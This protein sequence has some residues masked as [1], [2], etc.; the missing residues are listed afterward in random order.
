MSSYGPPQQYPLTLTNGQQSFSINGAPSGTQQIVISCQSYPSAGTLSLEYK[1]V[2]DSLWRP[3]PKGT[4]LPL[5]GPLVLETYG[6]V[7][8]YRATLAGIVGGAGLVAWIGIGNAEGFPPGS[9]V[10]LRALTTQSYIEANV[11]NG[12]QYEVSSY[13]AALAPLANNDTVFITGPLPVIVKT[14]QIGFDATKLE[15][16]VFKD[17]VFTGGSVI[18]YYNLN[19]RNPVVGGVIIR[20]GATIT[21]AGTEAGAPTYM[22][23][24]AGQGQNTVGAYQVSGLERLLAPNST[25]M[26]R[27][28]NTG[29]APCQVSAYISWYEGGTDLPT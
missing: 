26:L 21:N 12:V 11:K 18:P 9:F 17:T 27:V 7:A 8:G 29:A 19:L 2:G 28:T 13:I 5:A 23:G 4:L 24:S 1:L 22:I 15:A 10:G 6:P 14:R 16:H 20:A 25:Y 3:V